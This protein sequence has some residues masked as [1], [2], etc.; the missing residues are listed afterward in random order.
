M[1]MEVGD[2]KIELEKPVE[3]LSATS[4]R[5]FGWLGYALVRR[6]WINVT[7]RERFPQESQYSYT[8]EEEVDARET[9]A[10]KWGQLNEKEH[11]PDP[12]P[13]FGDLQKVDRAGFFREYVWYC[14]PHPS[15][16]QPEGL[17]RQ[18]FARWVSTQL[19]NHR[20]ETWVSTRAK[21]SRLR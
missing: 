9:A 2:G 16:K 1:V 8:F 15:W 4:G 14:V 3:N 11:F 20:V 19:P 5:F 12:D 18:A 10:K 13:Y 21:R 17:R 6:V 7:F